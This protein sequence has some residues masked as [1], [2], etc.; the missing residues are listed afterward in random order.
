M[1][2][3]DDLYV[4]QYV[5]KGRLDDGAVKIGRSACPEARRSSLES[6]Q[7]FRLQL[8]VVFKG[9][10]KYEKAVHLR[11]AHVNS[12][13]GA[14]KEWFNIGAAEAAKEIAATVLGEA[15]ERCAKRART[16]NGAGEGARDGVPDPLEAGLA[17]RGVV[18]EAAR[19][20]SPRPPG[21]LSWRS[22]SWLVGELA[23]RTTQK[24]A[25]LDEYVYARKVHQ[26]V[27]HYKLTKTWPSLHVRA[28]IPHLRELMEA[29]EA[30]EA[31]DS[32]AVDARS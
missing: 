18:K 3:C 28:R 16:Q 6:C 24:G 11:L 13:D 32:R 26:L 10:G 23:R 20:R 17:S 14:G 30:A 8:S 21:V 9:W 4:M 29:G 25:P 2:P 31:G 27:T 5:L 15:S 7:N 1:E 12:R 22:R 19:L